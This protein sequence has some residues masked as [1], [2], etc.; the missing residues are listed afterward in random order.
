MVAET[1]ELCPQWL[2]HSPGHGSRAINLAKPMS[3]TTRRLRRALRRAADALESIP[4]NPG[5]SYWKYRANAVR[6]ARLAA[7]K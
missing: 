5:S 7:A 6:K 3:T 4:I 2:S 1:R